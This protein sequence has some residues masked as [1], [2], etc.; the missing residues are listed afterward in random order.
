MHDFSMAERS[1]VYGTVGLYHQDLLIYT[2]KNRLSCFQTTI[3]SLYSNRFE[4][5]MFTEEVGD[6]LGDSD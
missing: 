1:A 2:P 4:T 6:L 3:L 5:K